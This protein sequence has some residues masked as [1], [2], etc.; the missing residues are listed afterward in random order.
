MN[1]FATSRNLSYMTESAERLYERVLILRIQTGDEAAFAELVERYHARLRYYLRKMLGD[2]HQADDAL[3]D[4]WLDVFRALPRLAD[5]GAF[6]AWLYRIARDRAFRMLR[7]RRLPTQ[8]LE[9]V[10]LEATDT[11]DEFSPEDAAAIHALLDQLKPEHREALLLRFLENMSYEQ[12]AS[13]ANVPVGTV[14]SRLHHAKRELRRLL[15][16][17]N[18]HERK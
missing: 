17:T 13:V 8:S 9:A 4:V 15:E 14:R 2:S 10:A 18:N 3:Q 11:E 6:A 1:F 12:I 7:R 16:R 5:P